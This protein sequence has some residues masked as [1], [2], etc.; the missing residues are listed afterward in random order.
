MNFF[1]KYNK[2]FSLGSS[3]TPIAINQ[4]NFK[5]WTSN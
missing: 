5:R 2:T 4:L 1:L 3:T